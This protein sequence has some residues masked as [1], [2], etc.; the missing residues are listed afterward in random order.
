MYVRALLDPGQGEE[1]VCA[2]QGAVA[3][4]TLSGVSEP[5]R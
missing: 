1:G 3:I 5:E 4:V 2:R